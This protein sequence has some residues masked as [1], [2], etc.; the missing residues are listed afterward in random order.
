MPPCG[1]ISS[2]SSVRGVMNVWHHNAESWRV[3]ARTVQNIPT[4]LDMETTIQRHVDTGIP[5]F[6]IYHYHG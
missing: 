3:M 6:E 2:D 1:G 5:R 4:P